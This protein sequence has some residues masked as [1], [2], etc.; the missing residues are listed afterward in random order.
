MLL[1]IR[2]RY[3]RKINKAAE[4]S[5]NLERG[6]AMVGTSQKKAGLQAYP[7][8]S[9]GLVKNLKGCISN[10]AN[11]TLTIYTRAPTCACRVLS[12]LQTGYPRNYHS[13][14]LQFLHQFFKY[15]HSKSLLEHL[16]VQLTLRS[17]E[18]QLF[19]T[20]I[21]LPFHF[22]PALGI[23]AILYRK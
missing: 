7:H 15:L 1:H 10:A 3:A 20:P 14:L 13:W 2:Q 16:I 9:N 12:F 18:V 6:S 8:V 4:M 11:D 19:E 17:R 5:G 23:P 21:P 22:N